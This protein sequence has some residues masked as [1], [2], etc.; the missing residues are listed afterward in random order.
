MNQ[1]HPSKESR[2]STNLYKIEIL[3]TSL[4]EILEL[5]NFSH[6]IKSAIGFEQVQK[7]P[8]DIIMKEP[9]FQ[10][11]LILRRVKRLK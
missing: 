8:S 4:T 7:F 9:L 5:S 1:H 11:D 3:I 6:M 2:F 10:N